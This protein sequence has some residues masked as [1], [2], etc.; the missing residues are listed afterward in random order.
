MNIF[1][2]SGSWFPS[3]ICFARRVIGA[4]CFKRLPTYFFAMDGRH[5]CLGSIAD[6]HVAPNA[7]P[8][9][10]YIMTNIYMGPIRHTAGS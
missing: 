2:I 5:G 6:R 7:D 10:L 1:L 9:R 3:L 8:F 4:P